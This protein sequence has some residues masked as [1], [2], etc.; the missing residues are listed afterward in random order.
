[1]RALWLFATLALLAGCTGAPVTTSSGTLP[2]T[3]PMS[4][5]AHCPRY[6]KGTGLLADGD[7][8]GSPDPGGGYLTF[9]KGQ[10]LA[11]NWRVTKLNIDLIGT[12]FW[13]VAHLC[14]VDLDGESAVGGIE[15]HGFQTQD[16]AKYLLSFLMSGNDYCGPTI[17]KMRVIAG[18]QNVVFQWNA[19]HGHSAEKGK[20]APRTL[21]F[22]AVS[23]STV[24]KFTSLDYAGSG[25]GPVIAAVA[26]TR[27]R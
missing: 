6:S 22:A 9:S 8:H 20:F 1:M 19:A 4:G 17:K 21:K 18:N 27:A 7:F 13:N 24:L 16:N 14:S 25:C 10:L 12:T 5:S 23:K 3:A 11:P 15:H 2:Q 26:V